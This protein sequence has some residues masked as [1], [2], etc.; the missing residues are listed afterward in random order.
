MHLS[1]TKYFAVL[2]LLANFASPTRF[3]RAPASSSVSE[4]E[5]TYADLTDA[6]GVLRAI[7]SGL[8]EIY[9]GKD[10]ATWKQFY[11]EKRTEVVAGLAKLSSDGLS[12]SDARAVSLMRK[13]LESELPEDSGRSES[14]QP[15]GHCQDAQGKD[16]ESSKLADA[17]YSCF[18]EIGNNLQFE[19]SRLT[20]VGAFGFLATLDDPARRKVLFL[21]FLPLWRS[22]NGQNESDSPYRR[23]IRAVAADATR[24]DSGIAAAA[25]TLGIQPADV[26]RWLEQILDSW[27]QASG[28]Q[29]IEP[30]DYYY[31]NG[32][33]ERILAASIPRDSLLPITEH[34]YR[35]LGADLKQLG[36]LYDLDPRPGKAPLAY[37][38]FVTLGRQVNRVW[39]PSVQRISANYASGGLSLLNEFVHENG[40][41]VH[42]AAVRNRPAF[43]DLGDSLFVEAFADV[44]SWDTYDRSWQQKYLGRSAPQSASLQNQY[45]NVMLDAAWALFELRMLQKP[46]ADPNAVWTNITSHY[47]HIVPH[48]EWSWWAERVQL[49]DP[50]YMVNY[51]LGAVVT[52]DIRQRTR[53]SIGAFDTGNPRWYPWISDNL[54]R[55]G[56]EREAADLLRSFLG[57]AVSPQAL[58]DDILRVR[59]PAANSASPSMPNP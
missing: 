38:D 35:D 22:I 50:G 30:W 17:L 39:R 26:K 33:A 24:R 53:E 55:F 36:V 6:S 57:R 47:L 1:M 8:F 52:A 28:D 32:E 13:S 48:P 49:V 18:D 3:Q 21:A 23:R 59:R 56:R 10:R 4:V 58:L 40:H 29:P 12:S 51:G 34:Y 2:L 15:S 45:S 41:A 5:I 37:C 43:M 7:D 9:Q 46:D 44:T 31:I 20:R 25:R 27:R 19:G 54:L 14:L 16:I 42:G 11:Q